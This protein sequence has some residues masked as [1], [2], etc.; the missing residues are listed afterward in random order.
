[1]AIIAG[2]TITR[3]PLVEPDCHDHFQPIFPH[4]DLCRAS[5]MDERKQ[6]ESFITLWSFVRMR[7][8][9]RALLRGY[10]ASVGVRRAIRARRMWR[11][12][13]FS[14]LSHASSCAEP[15]IRLPR[16]VER[17]RLLGEQGAQLRDQQ[18]RRR[19]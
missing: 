7:G 1:M 2:P 9:S 10:R 18:G 5:L 12:F 3:P 4:T 16:S 13:I 6:M 14:L 19:L 15:S 11:G 8:N 17:N